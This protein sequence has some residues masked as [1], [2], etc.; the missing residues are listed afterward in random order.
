[1]PFDTAYT[2]C[3]HDCP[4]ACALAVERIDG[5]RIGRVHGAKGQSYT[6]GVVCAKVARYADRQHHPERLSVPLRRV[7]GK[8]VGR[9][10]FVPISWNDALDEVAEHFTLAAQ[11]HGP[12]TVW[13][14]Y[15]AGTMGRVQRDGI[16]RLRHAMR[17]SRELTTICNFLTDSGWLAGVGAKRGVDAREIAKS[18]LIIAWGGNP[19]STQVNVMTHAAKARHERGAK[20]AVVD[21]YRTGTAK[22]ADLHLAPLPGTD[23][24]LACAVMHVLFREG[25]ADRDYLARYADD[26]GDLEAHLQSRTPEWAAAITGLPEQQILD[27]A[28]LYGRTKRSYIR[29]GYGFSRQRNG[30]MQVFAVTCLP[31]VTGAWQYE[32]GGAHYS[33]HGMLPLDLTLVEGLDALDP[34]T[35]VLDQS[36]IGPVLTGDKRDLGGGPPVTALLVQNTNPMVVAPESGLVRDGFARKDLFVCVHEQFLTETAAMADIVLPATTFL[37]HDDIYT[38]GGHTFLQ[39]GRGVLPPHAECRSNH[40]VICGLA[41]RLDARH[42]GFEMTAFE[43]IEHMLHDSG[44]PGPEAF[45]EGVWLDCW[46]GFETGHFLDGFG[47]ADGRFHFRADWA[48][49]GAGHA[50][51]PAFADHVSVLDDGDPERPFRLVA[52]PSRSFLNTSFNNIPAGVAREGRPTALVHPEVLA[53]LGIADGARVRLGNA[54]GSVVVHARAFEGLQQRLVVV[55]GLWPNHAFEEGIG[56]NLL[57]S[58]DPGLPGGG[59]VFHDTSVW[60]RPA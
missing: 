26:S 4:S 57:T 25:Y 35:R 52:A 31:T 59:A 32:G 27:F 60:L 30:A 53:A 51:L 48:A 28:R 49:L 18:D 37:E 20:L 56:I 14:Y 34:G 24:A 22:V 13:P 44:L 46:P 11:R 47:H 15:Y 6:R 33:N 10:A 38:A 5:N 3:P 2:V 8:G 36:R 50:A 39:I 23:A 21:P 41:A 1:V 40:D 16:N 54:K 58:A 12:E 7:G 45:E 19:V 42:P 9:A 17:Y 29:L 55:E 43:I